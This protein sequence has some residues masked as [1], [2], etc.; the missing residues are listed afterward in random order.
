MTLENI[1]FQQLKSTE[2]TKIERD[3]FLLI[4]KRITLWL[5]ID[6]R[7]NDTILWEMIEKVRHKEVIDEILV[8]AKSTAYSAERKK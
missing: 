6:R 5:A 8:H 4:Q 3:G 2:K 1:C 7:E